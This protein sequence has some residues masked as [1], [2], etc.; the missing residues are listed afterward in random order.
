MAEFLYAS[1]DELDDE[2]SEV[3]DRI[4]ELKAQVLV[5]EGVNPRVEQR[6]EII[7]RELKQAVELKKFP[8]ASLERLEHIVQELD[9]LEQRAGIM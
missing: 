4:E 8:A 9:E 5:E 1:T 2:L 6:I 3:E 7:E